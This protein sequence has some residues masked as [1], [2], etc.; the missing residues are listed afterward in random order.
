MNVVDNM[1]MSIKIVLLSFFI[2][3]LG[4]GLYWYLT[5]SSSQEEKYQF[6]IDL[7]RSLK[8]CVDSKKVNLTNDKTNNLEALYLAQAKLFEARNTMLKWEKSNNSDIKNLSLEF[9]D[10]LDDLIKSQDLW[11]K[12]FKGIAADYETSLALAKAKYKTGEE[13][14]FSSSLDIISIISSKKKYEKE[15]KPFRY[16][17]SKEQRSN[18]IHYI[19]TNFEKELREYSIKKKQMQDRIIDNYTLSMPEWAIIYIKRFIETGELHEEQ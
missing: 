7:I 13:K 11:V 9:L 14:L 15:K 18:V 1:K 12:I 2:I 10:G 4:V 16:N 8:S 6:T 19:D 17:L 5:Y 3:T